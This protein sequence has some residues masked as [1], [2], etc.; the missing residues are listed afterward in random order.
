MDSLHGDSAMR[1][2]NIS[3]LVK[4]TLATQV[5]QVMIQISFTFMKK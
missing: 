5:S 4:V 2:A 1:C 3:W